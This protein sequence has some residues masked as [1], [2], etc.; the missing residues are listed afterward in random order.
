VIK[1][2][3]AILIFVSGAA[4][5]RALLSGRALEIRTAECLAR[6]LGRIRAE[7]RCRLTPLPELMGFAASG[8]GRETAA[9]WSA[10]AEGT[11]RGGRPLR[12]IW[13][14]ETPRLSLDRSALEA[15]EEFPKSFEGLDEDGVLR[16]IDAA[17][18][19][20]SDIARKKRAA[21]RDAARITVCACFSMSA[22]L[23]IL[24]V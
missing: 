6:D 22:L 1:L 24:L 10:V 18:E 20:L 17:A 7:I 3:G 23:A 12:D 8:A 11:A 19:A 13:D 9:F 5:C 4:V 16:R 14:S 21:E 2:L 15:L